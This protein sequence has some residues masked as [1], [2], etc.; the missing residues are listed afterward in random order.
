MNRRQV[1]PFKKGL[2]LPLYHK[3]IKSDW[4]YM[5]FINQWNEIFLV[6]PQIENNYPQKGGKHT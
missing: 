4:N 3:P 5:N 6:I 1:Q 2:R